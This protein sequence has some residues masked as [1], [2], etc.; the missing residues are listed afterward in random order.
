[1]PGTTSQAQTPLKHQMVGLLQGSFEV[2][3]RRACRVLGFSR[4]TQRRKSPKRVKDL[5]LIE[6]LR[7]LAEEIP[8][9]PETSQNLVRSCHGAIIV[10]EQ[11]RV[12]LADFLNVFMKRA[13]AWQAEINSNNVPLASTLETS[14]PSARKRGFFGGLI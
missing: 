7:T 1:M 8:A 14:G 6:R 5:V 2:S 3:E 4:T 10:E 9:P 12:F 13:L 11:F